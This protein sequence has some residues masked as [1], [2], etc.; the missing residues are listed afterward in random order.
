M[1]SRKKSGFE[2]K[3]FKGKESNYF[4]C[5]DYKT[6]NLSYLYQEKICPKI[7]N[8]KPQDVRVLDLGCALGN[9]LALFD[10]DGFITYGLD[11]SEFAIKK[12]AKRTK[13]KLIKADLNKGLPFEAN[14]F[15]VITAI[16]V[17]EHLQSP[18]N[19]LLEAKRVLRK[20][21]LLFLQTP[22]ISSL[23]VKIL[24]DKWFGY[25]DKTH[26]YL[27]SKESLKFLLR[28]AGFEVLK[29]EVVFYPAPSFLRPVFTKVNIGGSLWIVAKK[30]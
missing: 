5:L 15:N 6:G 26:L 23:F 20:D 28:Q 9:L 3:Y 2:E 1:I 4:A 7:R 17:I 25:Q 18:Y 24:K 22:N 10:K 16:D 11:I 13:A 12:A 27:F 8:R 14:F 21:G 30:V 29:D 19:F